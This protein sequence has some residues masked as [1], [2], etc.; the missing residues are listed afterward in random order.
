MGFI[1]RE[2]SAIATGVP[3]EEIK[4]N[5]TDRLV[6]ETPIQIG[7]K[8]ISELSQID[9]TMTTLSALNPTRYPEEYDGLLMYI[10]GSSLLVTY[11]RQN[12]PG[13]SPETNANMYDSSQHVVHKDLTKIIN[14]ELKVQGG[15]N[16]AQ[17]PEDLTGTLEGDAVTFSGFEPHVNDLFTLEIG[18]STFGKFQVTGVD[19]LSHRKGTCYKISYTLRGYISTAELDDINSGVRETFYFDKE[20]NLNTGTYSLFTKDDYVLRKD[21]LAKRQQFIREYVSTFY[22]KEALSFVRPDT[23]YDP[24]IVTY[25]KKILGYADTKVRPMQLNTRLTNYA[26]SIWYCLEHQLK[27]SHIKSSQ[28]SYDFKSSRILDADHNWLTNRQFLNFDGYL[29]SH[30]YIFS[31]NFYGGNLAGM[32]PVEVMVYKY[33]DDNLI[34]KEEFIQHI[35]GYFTLEPLDM[36]YMFPIYLT[37]LTDVIRRISY[38]PR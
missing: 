7:D 2:G 20:A 13:G 35:N 28:I 5:E 25:L 34:H 18:N 6:P 27:P 10:E 37:L 4:P 19:R 15:I 22:L 14:F 31:P 11:Y 32:T 30:S 38:I 21:L 12:F 26:N 9:D 3:V 23:V 24:Y 1:T 8:N 33:M 36:F 17:Q 16:Y 29:D